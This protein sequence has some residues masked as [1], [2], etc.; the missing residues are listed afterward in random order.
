[1]NALISKLAGFLPKSAQYL[2]FAASCTYW[3]GMQINT[4]VDTLRTDLVNQA[5]LPAYEII[6]N[7]LEK[8]VE[9]LAKDPEDI[10]QTDLKFAYNQ[11]NGD[12]RAVYVKSLV[13]S[14]SA[15]ID[16][17]CDKIEDMYLNERRYARN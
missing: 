15:K 6:Y 9:K 7:Q 4:S 11:C 16:N 12:F 3:L 2:L 10:K 14:E 8:Q 17:A 5:R 13:P 1:M